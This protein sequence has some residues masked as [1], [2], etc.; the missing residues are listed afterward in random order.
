VLVVDDNRINRKLVTSL[1][2]NYNASVHEAES[3]KQA[4]EEAS[5]HFFDLIFMDIHMPEMNG[6]E[7]AKAIR[8]IE[9]AG[10]RTPI[11]ALT[12]NAVRGERERLIRSGLDGCIIKPL[13]EGELFD[14][15]DKWIPQSKL[16]YRKYRIPQQVDETHL[17]QGQIIGIPKPKTSSSKVSKLVDDNPQ[18]TQD[19]LR[20]FIED[21]PNMKH[22]LTDA[23][24][25][26]DLQKI[27]VEAHKIHGAASCC[28]IPSVK[29]A[30]KNVE[31]Y[32]LRGKRDLIDDAV[33]TLFEAI[34]TLQQESNICSD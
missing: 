14:V 27:E 17:A 21:I 12:A 6:I 19:L 9:P 13:N 34:T 11:I 7:A 20:M 30:A 1:L 22:A 4:I 16:K 3:G 25:S 18:L 10:R 26:G 5:A 28:S 31:L 23:C 8:R 24:Q 32:A 29:E 2:R 33:T 15:L